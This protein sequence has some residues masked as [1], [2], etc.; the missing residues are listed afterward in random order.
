MLLR[1]VAALAILAG[2]SSAHAEAQGPARFDWFEYRG[3]DQQPTPSLRQ[4]GNP[5]LQG[6]YPDPSVL[7]VGDDYYLVNS[8]FSW[9]PGMPIFHSRDLVNWTQIGD[10]IDRTTQL[11]FANMNMGQGVYAP[12]LSWHNGKFY[13]LNTCTGCGGNY[14]LTANRAAG[15]W[16]NP[17]WLPDVDGIDTSLFFDDDG[18]SW[19]VHNGPPAG[20]PRYSGHTAIWLQQFDAKTLKTFG[21]HLL[22][23]DAGSHPERNPIWIEG[24]HIFKKDGFYYLIAA[25]GGTEEGHSEAVFRSDRPTGPYRP[26]EGNPILT[27]RDLPTDRRD[28]ITSTGHASFVRT[29]NGDWWAVFLCVRPYDRAGDFNT[30]RETCM[31]PVHWKDG[32]PRITE[33]GEVLPAIEARPK[34]PIGP[35]AMVRTSGTFTVRDDFNRPPLPPYWM[36]LRNPQGKWWRIS[37]GALELDARNAVLGELGNPSLLARRQQHQ[38]AVATTRLTFEPQGNDAEAGLVA[39]QNDD[40]W[41]FLAIG[42]EHGKRVIRVRRRSGKGDLVDGAILA[43]ASLPHAGAVELRIVARRAFYDFS[44]S[45]DGRTWHALLQNAD[46]TILSTKKAGGFVGAVMGLYAHANGAGASR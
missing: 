2:T 3:D 11:N 46:G 37:N 44:W 36:M 19:I 43:S 40:Y 7:R 28:P 45:L 8:T 34:L 24:P 30:G 5:I 16:S 21:P 15:P 35:K 10:A 18:S 14:V 38:N 42:L 12:D 26:Y 6:F 17:V 25:E 32:W 13:L 9:F 33:Q 1:S 20:K 39:L 29:Q 23:V 31:A 27:Q 22:L 41:Y 4:Y